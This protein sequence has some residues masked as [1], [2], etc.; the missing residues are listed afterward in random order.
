MI[1]PFR[2]DEAL[3]DRVIAQGGGAWDSLFIYPPFDQGD[4]GNTIGQ[5]S[6]LS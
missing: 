4:G 2:I 5:D 6:E 3:R 1:T